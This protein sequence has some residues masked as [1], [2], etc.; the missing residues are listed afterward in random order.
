[1]DVYLYKYKCKAW[2][3]NNEGI[4]NIY[5][6]KDISE[7][8]ILKRL[9]EDAKEVTKSSSCS[10]DLL[11]KYQMVMNSVK[12]YPNISQLPTSIKM[13]FEKEASTK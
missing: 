6:D 11:V 9:V 1:M 12:T 3:G 4:R 7:G 8:D 13:V 2:Y 5:T 10:V